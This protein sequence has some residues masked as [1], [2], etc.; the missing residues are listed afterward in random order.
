VNGFAAILG[1]WWMPLIVA[2]VVGSFLGVLITRL[3]AGE[4]VAIG[5]SRCSSCGHALGARDLVP[6][7]SWV[8]LNRRC[9]YCGSP[10]GWFYPAIELAAIIVPIWAA[11]EVDGWLLW[12]TCAL[13]WVLLTLAVIDARHLL[14]PDVLTLPLLVGG[15]AVAALIE[16][17]SLHEHAIGAIAGFVV[18]WLI[19]R[20]YR[21]VRGREGLGLGDAKFLAAAGAWVSWQGLPS[22]VFIGAASALA[23]AVTRIIAGATSAEGQKV[24]FGTFLCL[25]TWIVWLYGPMIVG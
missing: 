9:R 22:V 2:P 4:A 11:T 13:G 10:I 18:F 15:L 8:V 19:A 17:A 5:R 24:P 23:F 12:A 20:G 7:L 3:P 6:L 1:S 21:L 25:S 16:S 14:L